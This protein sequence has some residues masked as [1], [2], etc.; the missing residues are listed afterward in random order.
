MT[1][2]DSK[3]VEDMKNTPLV[4]VTDDLYE[5]QLTDIFPL[6]RSSDDDC[7]PQFIYPQAAVEPEDLQYVK[8]EP[9]DDYDTEDTCFT[10]QVR[11]AICINICSKACCRLFICLFV[12]EQKI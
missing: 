3:I 2:C 5:L 11:S 4:N 7:K 6:E 1:D 9:A 12:L 8:Q 10:I